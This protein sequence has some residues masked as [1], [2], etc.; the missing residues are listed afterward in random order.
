MTHGQMDDGAL[1]GKFGGVID[2]LLNYVGRRTGAGV[3]DGG[4]SHQVDRAQICLARPKKKRLPDM[5]IAHDIVD[6]APAIHEAAIPDPNVHEFQFTVCAPVSQR[7]NWQRN[8]SFSA[9]P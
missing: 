4:K 6:A 9:W 3:V 7:M 5:P 8:T 2:R 1:A